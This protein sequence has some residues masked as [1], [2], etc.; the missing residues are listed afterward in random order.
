MFLLDALV[1][2][3]IMGM[4]VCIVRTIL[5]GCLV[6]WIRFYAFD[7]R[8]IAVYALKRAIG[9]SCFKK[10]WQPRER[11]KGVVFD[12]VKSVFC[13]APVNMVILEIRL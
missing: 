2:F 7:L 6:M 10:H 4:M 5:R 3:G 1:E 9:S 8:D 11:A 13:A 12:C